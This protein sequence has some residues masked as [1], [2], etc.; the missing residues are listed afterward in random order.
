M[1]FF[2]IPEGHHSSSGKKSRLLFNV[3]R[4]IIVS[5]KEIVL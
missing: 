4:G 1:D 5:I 3:G 2:T